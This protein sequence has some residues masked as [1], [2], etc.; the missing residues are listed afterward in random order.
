[1]ELDLVAFKRC[2]LV[3]IFQIRGKQRYDLNAP[4]SRN[5]A[6]YV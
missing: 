5:S 1:M 4:V 6:M 2:D 3:V